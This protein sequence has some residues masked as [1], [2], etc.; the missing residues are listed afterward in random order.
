MKQMHCTRR[1]RSGFSMLE[2]V[3]AVAIM[4]LIAGAAIPVVAKTIERA[5]REATRKEL[6]A[7]A[8]A[9]L[10]HVRDTG[11][12][13]ASA[14]ELGSS[15][16]TPGWSGP[17]LGSSTIDTRSGL[18]SHEVDGWSR[19]YRFVPS[20]RTLLVESSGPDGTFGTSDDLSTTIDATPIL[21][22]LTLAELD[23]LNGAIVAY[24][25][26]YLYTDPLPGTWSTALSRLVTTGFLPASSTFEQ[27]AFGDEYVG[28]PPGASPMVM[29]RSENLG[30]P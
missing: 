13:P 18:P 27:D 11:V 5:A 9:S 24:N 25:D 22:E 12:L 19:A 14:A 2:I 26:V 15:S 4:T 8:G 7:I 30:A 20:T 3:V 23:V 21:R 29:V 17:Y 1:D 16:S 6:D 28:V 10:E